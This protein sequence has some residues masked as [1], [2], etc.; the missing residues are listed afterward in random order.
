MSDVIEK[1]VYYVIFEKNEVGFSPRRAFCPTLPC[2]RIDFNSMQHSVLKLVYG[3]AINPLGDDFLRGSINMYLHFISF[4]RI[5]VTQVV[6]ILPHVRQ[7]PTSSTQSIPW[8]LMS[9]RRKEP[10]HHHS[11]YLLYWT[12]SIQSP[13]VKGFNIAF[14]LTYTNEI[15]TVG[16]WFMPMLSTAKPL[17]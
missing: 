3:P 4:L 1:Y 17:I 5:D 9:W 16:L 11:W 14:M 2:A 7:G 15:T 13:H 12:G 8:V 6:E 10:G